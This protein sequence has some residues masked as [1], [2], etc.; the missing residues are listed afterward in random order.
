MKKSII[1]TIFLFPMSILFFASCGKSDTDET[2]KSMQTIKKE[3]SENTQAV[4]Q[5]DSSAEKAKTIDNLQAAYKGEI[6]ANAKYIAYAQKAEQEGYPQIASLYKAIS[7]AELIHAGNHQAVLLESKVI[8]PPIKPEFTVKTTKENLEGDIK[9]EAYEVTS[10]YPDFIKSAENANNQLAILSFTYA[11]KT[12]KK[13]NLMY[14]ETFNAL[15]INSVKTLPSVFYVCTLCGNTYPNEAP[16]R[17]SF[18]MTKSDKFLKISK[19]KANRDIALND[20]DM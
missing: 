17:C 15:Q 8:V 9:G 14:I 5:I 19:A 6:T 10:M 18:C 20:C 13:H 7:A 12:E 1:T 2:S 4:A 16:S 11:M 3:S